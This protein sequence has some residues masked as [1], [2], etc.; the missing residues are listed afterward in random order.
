MS[1]WGSWCGKQD[2]HQ[3]CPHLS[4]TISM[5]KHKQGTLQQ[6]QQQQ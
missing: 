2:M 5:R 3:G 4:C 6:Q 1:K